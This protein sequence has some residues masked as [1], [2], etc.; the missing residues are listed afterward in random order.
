MDIRYLQ[1][2][3]AVICGGSSAAALERVPR[4]KGDSPQEDVSGVS[5]SDVRYLRSQQGFN[6]RKKL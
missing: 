6:P 3:I 4:P 2:A 1:T 5:N